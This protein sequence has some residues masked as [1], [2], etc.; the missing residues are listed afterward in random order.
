MLAP[1][2]AAAHRATVA[3]GKQLAVDAAL[4]EASSAWPGP[5]MPPEDAPLAAATLRGQQAD[6]ALAAALLAAKS[7]ASAA[8]ERVRV[9]AL[10]WERERATADALALRVAEAERF[11]HISSGQLPV[12][13][14]P[15][16]SSSR[17]APP[18]GSG[19]RYNPTDPM[20]AQLHLQA[21]GVQNIR[22][23][24]SVLLDPA[25]SSYGR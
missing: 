6:A 12:D 14:E 8:Q 11:L 15:G 9:A 3:A 23:L 20:V 22:A 1:A 13:P 16:S 24:V 2:G 5:G 17:R 18:A 19:A 7:E 21:A 25:S 10:A 4:P